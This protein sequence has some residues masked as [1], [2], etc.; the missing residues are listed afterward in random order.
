MTAT[1]P[2]GAV[3]VFY[4]AEVFPAADMIRLAA[5][6]VWRLPPG[7]PPGGARPLR[8]SSRRWGRGPVGWLR[9]LRHQLWLHL[10]PLGVDLHLRPAR[11]RRGQGSRG[12]VRSSGFAWDDVPVVYYESDRRTVRLMGRVHR[13]PPGTRHALVLLVDEGGSPSGA[14]RVAVRTVPVPSVRVL[15][16][17]PER[18]RV[19]AQMDAEHAPAGSQIDPLV[20]GADVSWE[21]ALRADAAVRA[22]MDGGESV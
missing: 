12:G 2:H 7:G 17:R 10:G 16:R 5:A 9:R 8:G 3:E 13:L 1:P 19:D 21:A 4:F 15:R 20:G 22:F 11:D 14:L 6:V 18:A